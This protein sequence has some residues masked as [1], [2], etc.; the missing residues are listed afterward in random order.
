MTDIFDRAAEREEEM[1]SDALSKQARRSGL[2]GKTIAD[3]ARACRLC[4]A[5]IPLA[6][7]FA[8][9]GVE[10]CIDCQRMLEEGLQG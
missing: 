9:P 5:P 6:R 10:T 3:S 7:R 2:S 1:R 8:L 4:D